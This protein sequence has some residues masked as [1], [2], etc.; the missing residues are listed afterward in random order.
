MSDPRLVDPPA[1][2]GALRF[3]LA[4]GRLRIDSPE[5]TIDVPLD[6][7]EQW[8]ETPDHS[9]FNLRMSIDIRV[10]EVVIHH[11][12][13]SAGFEAIRQAWLAARVSD[14]VPL[15]LPVEEAIPEPEPATPIEVRA[16]ISGP[17]LIADGPDWL[18]FV[19]LLDTRLLASGQL[20]ASE[21]NG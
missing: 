20:L 12:T 17:P 2:E 14:A 21:E 8:T 3:H 15:A 16:P 9:G 18:M 11:R 6:T 5:L 10:S 13:D 7:I 1:D 4:E 19:P